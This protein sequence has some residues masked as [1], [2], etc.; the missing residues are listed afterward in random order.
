MGKAGPQ[1]TCVGV[2]GAPG[3]AGRLQVQPSQEK[4]PQS[5]PWR[6]NTRNE[7][8]VCSIP[9]LLRILPQ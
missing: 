5:L 9:S 3:A 2:L 1:K 7:D 6:V 4:T 8:R